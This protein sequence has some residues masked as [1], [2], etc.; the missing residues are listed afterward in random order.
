MLAACGGDDDATVAPTEP[1]PVVTSADTAA[2]A[3]AP[4]TDPPTDTAAPVTEPTEAPADTE[5]PDTTID[6]GAAP[7]FP[8]AT[9]VVGGQPTGG[10]RSYLVEMGQT[11]EITIT[12]DVADEA[13][14]HGYDLDADLEPG[15]PAVFT[16]TADMVGSF[17]MELHDAGTLLFYLDVV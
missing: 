14:L 17:E 5:A 2:P 12:S 1:A 16:F 13:H 6:E 8:I 9:E 15:V 7:V 11:V 3:T 4:A 10:V